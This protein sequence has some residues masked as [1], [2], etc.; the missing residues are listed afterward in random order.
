MKIGTGRTI[1]KIK[2]EI[3]GKPRKNQKFRRA[4][5]EARG[6]G[7]LG[8]AGVHSAGLHLGSGQTAAGRGVSDGKGQGSRNYNRRL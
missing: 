4:A 8:S 1:V 2:Q 7:L 5:D 3:A 6:L